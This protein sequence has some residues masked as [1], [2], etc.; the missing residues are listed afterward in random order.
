MFKK[1]NFGTVAP[2]F[3]IIGAQKAGTS[4]LYYYLSQH[5]ELLVPETK[6]LHYF[7]TLEPTP[8]RDYLKLF[9]KSYGTTK[10]SFEATPRYMY[11]PGTAK[12]IYDFN[13][14]MKFIIMLRNPVNR[15]YSAWNMYR[16]MAKDKAQVKAFVKREKKDPNDAMFSYLYKN[17]FPTFE[18]WIQKEL[19]SGFSKKIIEPSIVKRGYYKKQLEEYLRFFPLESF[20]F[21]PFEFFKNSPI[22]SLDQVSCFLNIATFKNILIDLKPINKREYKKQISP[23]TYRQLELHYIEKNRGL[24][25][26]INL[27][28]DWM[29]IDNC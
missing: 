7:D 21:L 2:T 13:P 16:E 18:E 23:K 20:L 28:L 17:G 15:A 19:S 14:G 5:P 22:E 4:S 6:E 12:K 1:I 24:E 11:Y 9:P 29:K 26:M 3:M 25:E 8:K 10:Q 27:E